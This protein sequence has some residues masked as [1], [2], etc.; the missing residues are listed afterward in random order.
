[1]ANEKEDFFFLRPKT[2]ERTLVGQ[3]ELPNAQKKLFS[4]D[5]PKIG[6]VI[7]TFGAVPYVELG[8]AIRKRFYEAIPV[9][10]HDDASPQRDELMRLCDRYGATFQTNSGNLGHEMGD[11]SSMV[12]GLMWAKSCGVELLVKMSRRF[13][14]LA[15]WVS[16]L[17]TIASGTQ[18]ATFG[19][20]CQ[21]YRLPLRTECFAMAVEPWSR[22]EILDEISGF[23]LKNRRSL[24]LEQYV[25]GF[26]Y[27][28][29]EMNC[30]AARQW[31]RQ[32]IRYTPRPAIIPWD[33]LGEG[34]KTKSP[35][36]LWHDTS[37][38]QEYANL[39]SEM[40]LG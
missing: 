3:R 20:S 5:R 37:P 11:L 13:V 17:Q 40:G 39:A 4:S 7:S 16:K 1:M 21:A 27:R 33:F 14:P 31:E 30:E 12:S 6:L 19:R 38:P 32:N 10:V 26:A 36:Y 2:D 9:L 35:N 25:A 34:R 24:F 8:L 29:Y 28:A 22:V 18:Y 23:M 15:E